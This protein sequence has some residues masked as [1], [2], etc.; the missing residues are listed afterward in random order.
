MPEECCAHDGQVMILACSV[1]SGVGQL[2]NQAA[3]ELTRVREEWLENEINETWDKRDRLT[4]SYEGQ[5]KPRV[6]EI[7]KLLPQTNCRDCGQPTCLVFAVRVTEGVKGPDDC[8][9]LS[10]ENKDNLKEYL[11]PFRWDD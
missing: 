11:S 5:A 2:S 9:G 7:L 10:G 3:V 8:P 4:P 1:G 6:L